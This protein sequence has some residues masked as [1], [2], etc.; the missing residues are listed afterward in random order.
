MP[1][2]IITAAV[3]IGKA[4]AGSKI[5]TAAVVLAGSSYG[6]YKYEAWQR[7]KRQRELANQRPDPERVTSGAGEPWAQYVYGMA[8][9]DGYPFYPAQAYNTQ[10]R[11]RALSAGP[12]E[13][14][15][16]FDGLTANPV[17]II[18]G[19]EVVRCKRTTMAGGDKIEPLDGTKY[20]GAIEIREFFLADGTQG[21]DFRRTSPLASYTTPEFA[22]GPDGPW[23]EN[24]HEGDG[25]VREAPTQTEAAGDPTAWSTGYPV[26]TAAHRVQGYSW[27][28]VTFTQKMWE[29][30]G[31][32]VPVFQGSW[33]RI[34]FVMLGRKIA[35]YGSTV[36]TWSN[37]A[38]R[39]RY[40]F[41]RE[42]RGYT[43]AQIDQASYNAA[44]TLCGQT[45]DA[46][47]EGQTS[48][49]APY[50]A[51]TPT[52][53]RYTIDGA[54]RSNEAIADIEAQMD[55][56]WAGEVVEDGGVHYMEP[57]AD[58]AATY[59][60]GEDDLLTDD[61]LA[62]SP[63]K[64]VNERDNAVQAR[65]EQSGDHGL[66]PIDL[67]VFRDTAAITRDGSTRVAAVDFRFVRDPIRATWL[68]RVNL[69]RQR[70]TDTKFVVVPP[71][72][73]GTD[74][75]RTAMRPVQRVS[76]TFPEHGVSNKRYEIAKVTFN[77]D[78][79]MGLQLIED[80]DGTYGVTLGADGVRRVSLGVPP[81]PEA[82]FEFAES[83]DI[84]LITGLTGGGYAVKQADGTILNHLTPT[85]DA[86]E[87][88][89]ADCEYRLASTAP[90]GPW[91]P[92]AVVGN[93]AEAVGVQAGGSLQIRARNKTA[94]SGVGAWTQITYTLA[95]DLTPPATPT[96]LDLTLLPRGF[97]LDFDGVS[98]T[99]VAFY[100]VAVG[101]T[102]TPATVV[103]ETPGTHWTSPSQYT[104][105][106]T[107][108][109][110][111]RAV[112]RRGNRGAWSSVVTG[113]P[114]DFP[115]GA[116]GGQIYFIDI[117]SNVALPTAGT[118][119]LV[120]GG[121]LPAAASIVAGSVA[122]DVTDGRLWEWNATTMAFVLRTRVKGGD[123]MVGDVRPAVCVPNQI[124]MD[125]DGSIWQC[126]AAGNGEF[127]T[128]IKIPTTEREPAVDTM[129]REIFVV[130]GWPPA[131]SVGKAGD[132]AYTL[133][134]RF[135]T[136]GRIRMASR[137]TYPRFEYG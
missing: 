93:Q 70:E 120:G 119:E 106:T 28:A 115:A 27:V 55:L 48:L 20:A 112:D 22:P 83:V 104:A 77:D 59:T 64:T 67:P 12:C 82:R 133:D 9:V 85:W 18:G 47:T 100:E 42:I 71:S 46:R 129:G 117:A 121:T 61:Q 111:V 29:R 21:G 76:C 110:R 118:T 66:N 103:G 113:A 6:T 116:A 72:P 78:L 44:V 131:A 41:L 35:P 3:A 125:G 45:L 23:D 95:G 49:P 105:G 52:F 88:F 132:G 19:E 74:W 36:K 38:A 54:F 8:R 108:Y 25:Y 4:I 32:M 68:Q 69:L 91:T 123:F 134:G 1:G 99:D 7:A 30:D 109:L 57:G 60:L 73:D 2:P 114:L 130:E 96:G 15:C 107:Y 10:I 37:N 24:Y 43:D 56:A 26:W 65:M 90:G 102:A 16:G 122:V 94:I 135:G 127:F 128:G 33:P 101:T 137:I 87:I 58:K 39:V 13:G 97:F 86:T 79:T 40:D 92:M 14:L 51:Y 80:H 53:A 31:Q 136:R 63:H 89:L 11:F 124:R 75:T 62:T 126:N 34:E 81:L 98:D 17:I 5:A 84:P 50:A